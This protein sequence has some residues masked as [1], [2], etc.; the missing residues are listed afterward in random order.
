MTRASLRS[1]T[2]LL[3]WLACGCALQ[4]G[5]G[6]RANPARGP[7]HGTAIIGGRLHEARGSG[8]YASAD[9][10]LAKTGGF[11]GLHSI[12]LGAGL[13][14]K[15]AGALRFEFGSE[16]AFGEPARLQ[17]E[18]TGFF[19][20]GIFAVPVRVPVGGQHDNLTGAAPIGWAL[21]LV[22]IARAGRWSQS[23]AEGGK[24]QWEVGAELAIRLT[25]FSDL[26]VASDDRWEAP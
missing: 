26:I 25:G 6:A 3:A 11:I 23:L 19:V 21:D 4:I 16:F 2:V 18:P 12:A 24:G 8:P 14:L 15:A 5:S 13:R 1:S 7:V 22:P 17:Y 10:T 20:G 9:V